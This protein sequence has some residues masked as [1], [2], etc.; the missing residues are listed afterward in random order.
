MA[1]PTFKTISNDSSET[2]MQLNMVRP[3][4]PISKRQINLNVCNLGSS[5][6]TPTSGMSGLELLQQAQ[7]G[8]QDTLPHRQT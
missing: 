4:Y 5:S 7:R 8:Y 6:M 1:P 3:L 2:Q